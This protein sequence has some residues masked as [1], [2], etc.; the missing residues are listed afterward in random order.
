[1]IGYR[2]DGSGT[3]LGLMRFEAD[4]PRP[5]HGEVL[6]RMHAAALNY[7]DLKILSGNF[8]SAAHDLVPLSDGAGEIVGIG[9]GISQFAV[10]DRVT[11]T[12]FPRWISGAMP[13]DG[14][15]DQPGATRNGMLADH[16]LFHEAAL[17]RA[18]S[19]LTYVEAS[20][21]PCAALTAWQIFEGS[22]PVLPGE[23]VLTQGS[24]GVSLFSIQFARMAGAKIIATTS[25]AGKANRLRALGAHEVLNYHTNPEWGR[26]ARQA[27]A[28][29]GIDH[30]IEIGEKGTLE[31]VVGA[32][33]I[34][35][36]INIVGRADDSVVIPANL[37]MKCIATFRRISVGSRSSFLAMNKALEFHGTR[38]VI[39]KVFEFADAARAFEYFSRRGVFGKVVIS[40]S[41]SSS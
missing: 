7:L 35:A 31:Q 36:Q 29:Q 24:G 14:R 18:P 28:G 3:A 21:L 22:K 1:M 27:T 26:L 41:G 19:H 8:P 34:N 2:F 33:S 12:F 20:T 10:G 23:S 32:A 5:G 15:S 17:V 38:P 25:D 4:T 6:V 37:L 16:V 9:A 39:D 30:L 13:P 11:S 40:I